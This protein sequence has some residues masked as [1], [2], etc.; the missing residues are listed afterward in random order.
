MIFRDCRAC[1]GQR[2]AIERSMDDWVEC[3]ACQG[4]GGFWDEPD[5]E[6]GGEE[7][8]APPTRF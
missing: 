2:L 3:T 7:P 5:P 6:E 8:D 4:E 1:S